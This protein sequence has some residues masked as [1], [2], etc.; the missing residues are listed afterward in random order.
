[1][2]IKFYKNFRTKLDQLIPLLID[3]RINKSNGTYIVIKQHKQQVNHWQGYINYQRNGWILI[4]KLLI[5]SIRK[6]RSLLKL[7]NLSKLRFRGNLLDL[8]ISSQF[9]LSIFRSCQNLPPKL[10]MYMIKNQEQNIN[11]ITKN[12]YYLNYN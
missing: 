9:Y 8:Y 2:D 6:N 10:Q 12:D 1:M 5:K 11:I 3:E 7:G 4:K